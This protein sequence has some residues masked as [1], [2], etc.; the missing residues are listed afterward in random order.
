[1]T[2]VTSKT[3]QQFTGFDHHVKYPVVHSSLEDEDEEHNEDEEFL[4]ITGS[5][6]D[7]TLI[8]WRWFHVQVDHW[9]VLSLL[10]QHAT[11]LHADQPACCKAP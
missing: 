1:M 9:E 8:S 11:I 5:S 4:R 3:F 10:L 7:A 6:V 2:G